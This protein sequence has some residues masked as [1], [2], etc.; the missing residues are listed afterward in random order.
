MC[1]ATQ[2]LRNNGIGSGPVGDIPQALLD[3]LEISRNRAED[4][5]RKV[6]DAEAA[7]RELV[8]NLNPQ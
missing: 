2:L 4:A 8:S 1:L 7:L 3:R 5:V 6:L